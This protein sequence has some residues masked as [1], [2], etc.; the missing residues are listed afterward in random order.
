MWQYFSL[1]K[2]GSRKTVMK[3]LALLHLS[4]LF[5]LLPYF[6][7]ILLFLV[8]F[9]KCYMPICICS[10]YL[11]YG[12]GFRHT[13]Y[14]IFI[15]VKIFLLHVFFIGWYRLGCSF[16]WKQTKNWVSKTR[17]TSPCRGSRTLPLFRS[18]SLRESSWCS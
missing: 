7:D 12:T 5:F 6:Y 15:P 18:S 9:S 17:H 11:V 4:S 14:F 3:I 1:I 2:K 10:S 16:T 8:C 13:H